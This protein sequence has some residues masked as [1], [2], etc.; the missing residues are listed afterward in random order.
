MD[1]SR[2][3]A[4]LR[5][6]IFYPRSSHAGSHLKTS[7]DLQM[8]TAVHTGSSPGAGACSVPVHRKIPRPVHKAIKQSE[9]RIDNS[10]SKIV[11][12]QPKSVESLRLTSSKYRLIRKPKYNLLPYKRGQ[13]KL[14][15]NAK[16]MM[17]RNGTLNSE[18][19][20]G[21]ENNMYSEN[22]SGAAVKEKCTTGGST[23]R[24]FFKASFG[25][26]RQFTLNM[27]G[28]S[29]G[30]NMR[31]NGLKRRERNTA[32]KNKQLCINAT[33]ISVKP[34]S[35]PLTE[36]H[37]EHEL[38]AIC[39][40]DTSTESLFE[41]EACKNTE[42]AVETKK[43][44]VENDSSHGASNTSCALTDGTSADV[45]QC[46]GVTSTSDTMMGHSGTSLESSASQLYSDKAV[47]SPSLK[48]G[49]HC[50]SL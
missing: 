42:A 24:R 39:N 46:S 38:S 33:S 47:T 34:E 20:A 43:A 5:G 22:S 32:L 25:K 35:E 36:D 4:V 19:V 27:R 8:K 14:C 48:H 3:D 49:L 30:H 6:V 21:K 23:S 37:C 45:E 9:R 29:T 18:L 13:I 12:R 28:L 7:P 31:L 50:C 1:S 26:R 44:S 15:E 40:V 17:V 10:K 2:V 11:E 41:D 16:N